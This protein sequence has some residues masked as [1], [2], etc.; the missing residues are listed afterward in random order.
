MFVPCV[1]SSKL[2]SLNFQ[3]KLKPDRNLHK[4]LGFLTRDKAAQI[5]TKARSNKQIKDHVEHREDVDH[6][7]RYLMESCTGH[8]L[9]SLSTPGECDKR[10][11][12]RQEPQRK[13]TKLSSSQCQFACPRLLE[14]KSMW[15]KSKI[16]FIPDPLEVVPI[17]RTVLNNINFWTSPIYETMISIIGTAMQHIT[18]ASQYACSLLSFGFGNFDDINFNNFECNRYCG[19]NHMCLLRPFCLRNNPWRM[20]WLFDLKTRRDQLYSCRLLSSHM[21]T[22]W[23][24]VAAFMTW[25]KLRQVSAKAEQRCTK[26]FLEPRFLETEEIFIM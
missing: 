2:R 19:V 7:S 23:R 26:Y 12:N 11:G 22:I 1:R 15:M 14:V 6:V 17:L 8:S 5:F 25:W 16:F 20:V 4:D 13:T 18:S 10:Y 21:T 24:R 3:E 9:W